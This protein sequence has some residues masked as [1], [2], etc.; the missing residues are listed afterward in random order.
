[1]ECGGRIPGHWNYNNNINNE[2]PKKQTADSVSVT[3]SGIKL[4]VLL[5]QEKFPLRAAK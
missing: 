2:W 1:M 4:A 3:T 5:S